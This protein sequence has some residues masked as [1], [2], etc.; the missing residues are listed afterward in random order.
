M[1]GPFSTSRSGVTLVELMIVVA[2]FG[3]LGLLATTMVNKFIPSWRTRQ[4]AYQFMMNCNRARNLAISENVQYRIV[5]DTYDDQLDVDGPSKGIYR[6]ERGD[7]TANSSYFDILPVDADGSDDHT[8]E[9]YVDISYEGEDEMRGVSLQEWPDLIGLGGNDIVFN[10]RGWLDNPPEDFSSGNGYIEVTF[11]NK[12]G[13]M[14]NEKD[15]WTIKISRGGVIR[16]EHNNKL[17][18]PSNETG[19]MTSTQ[20]TNPTGFTG[21]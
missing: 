12:I 5:M 7:N 20:I 6:I 17:W 11:V 16:M 9:G 1:R 2:I 15:E 21:N 3:V 14:D 13:R 18:V 8:S 19:T 10:S 4:A